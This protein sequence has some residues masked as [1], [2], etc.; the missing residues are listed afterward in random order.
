[1][2]QEGEAYVSWFLEHGADPNQPGFRNSTP[3]AT[4]ASVGTLAVMKL[5]VAY[6]ARF[7]TLRPRTFEYVLTRGEEALPFLEYMLDNGVDIN[8]QEPKGTALHIAVTV[9]DPVLMRWL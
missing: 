8:E 2:I 7:E 6:G 3:L 9:D 5:L 4:A 1:M